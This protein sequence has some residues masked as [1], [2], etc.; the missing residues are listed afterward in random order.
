[1]TIDKHLT[2]GT[3][4]TAFIH[5][6][7]LFMTQP[8]ASCQFW[9]RSQR[10]SVVAKPSRVELSIQGLGNSNVLARPT[11]GSCSQSAFA[12][13]AAPKNRVWLLNIQSLSTFVY[14]LKN[15]FSSLICDNNCHVHCKCS[16]RWGAV[17]VISQTTSASKTLTP[18]VSYSLANHIKDSIA[19]IERTFLKKGVRWL[20]YRRTVWRISGKTRVL[21][22]P[23]VKHFQ[24]NK[25]TNRTQFKI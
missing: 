12:T 9:Q 14:I 24:I 22:I 11:P 13:L 5:K 2:I 10:H 4:Q 16:A 21:L 20:E 19:K 1:M 7:H 3:D 6:T 17:G 18:H 25:K 23:I 15:N 8:S